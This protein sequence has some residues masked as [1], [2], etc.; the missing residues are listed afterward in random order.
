MK[1]GASCIVQLGEGI[2]SQSKIISA[3]KTRSVSPVFTKP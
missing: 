2:K 3:I 1:V